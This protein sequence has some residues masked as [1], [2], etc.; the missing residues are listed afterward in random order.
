MSAAHQR[1]EMMDQAREADLVAAAQSG[2]RNG[3]LELVAYYKGPIYRLLYAL[4][5][6]AGDSSE[7]A[8]EAFTRGWQSIAEFPTGRRFLPWILK[9]AR[10]LPATLAA[11]GPDEGTEDRLLSVF[12]E[13]RADDQVAMA[14][15]LVE[16]IR[17]E[18]IAALL[19]VPASVAIL[20]ISQARGLLLSRVGESESVTA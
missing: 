7:L 18:E 3:F 4:T 10:N 19:D 9:I 12:G 1:F 6:N 11:N 14:L 8:Q 13:L 16:R 15:C 5:R 17:Y 2:D 20:R